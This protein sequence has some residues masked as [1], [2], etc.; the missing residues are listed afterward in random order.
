MIIFDEKSQ[1]RLGFFTDKIDMRDIEERG[2]IICARDPRQQNK[3]SSY[4]SFS[5]RDARVN[6]FEIFT[7]NS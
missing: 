6:L 5:S 1:A 7:K 2:K 3:E 4:F